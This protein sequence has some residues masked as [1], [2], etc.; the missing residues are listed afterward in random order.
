VLRTVTGCDVRLASVDNAPRTTCTQLNAHGLRRWVL[1]SSGS[2]GSAT[3][4]WRACHSRA[5]PARRW[6]RNSRRLANSCDEWR[7]RAAGCLRALVSTDTIEASTMLRY[8]QHLST[9]VLIMSLYVMQGELRVAKENSRR[10]E[11]RMRGI[12][13]ER[14]ELVRTYAKTSYVRVA[15]AIFRP[16]DSG[17]L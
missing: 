9:M 5:A 17:V 8:V 15:S 12:L 10:M 1:T 2:S 11:D 6:N 7:C 13:K 3:Q 4:P 16:Y 14:T